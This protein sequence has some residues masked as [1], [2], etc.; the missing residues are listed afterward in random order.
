MP[1]S[2]NFFESGYG[3]R[4]H[5]LRLY[6]ATYSFVNRARN[7]GSSKEE[8]A[9]ENEE[10]YSDELRDIEPLFDDNQ[11]DEELGYPEEREYSED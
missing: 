6:F 3:K 8:K 2:S 11:I 9:M 5:S 10:R 1:I 7:P 4:F